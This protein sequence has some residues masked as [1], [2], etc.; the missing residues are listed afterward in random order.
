MLLKVL[1]W[2][3]AAILA[4]GLLYLRFFANHRPID[5]NGNSPFPLPW[6]MA[7]LNNQTLRA[8]VWLEAVVIVV[9]AATIASVFP[10]KE[11]ELVHVTFSDEKNHFVKVESA[12]KDITANQNLVGKTLR[13]YVTERETIDKQT[14][15]LRFP[16]IRSMSSKAVWKTFEEGQ[17]PLYRT[18]GLT[19]QVVIQSDS[20]IA[21]GIHQVEYAVIDRIEGKRDPHDPKKEWERRTEFEATMTYIFAPQKVAY[22]DRYNNPIGLFVVKWTRA[23]R[24]VN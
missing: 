14:E 19:R 11:K 23:K 22:K 24:V 21:P 15:A 7:S 10:L 13:H 2:A 16:R 4:V 8:I 9:L 6:T 5:S 17:K 3:L 20:E 12:G 18:E 1:P